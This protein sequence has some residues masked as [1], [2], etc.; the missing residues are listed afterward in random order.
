VIRGKKNK[1]KWGRLGQKAFHRPITPH[2]LGPVRIELF[3][4]FDFLGIYDIYE[5]TTYY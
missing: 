1:K 2:R 3:C 5:K 4:P